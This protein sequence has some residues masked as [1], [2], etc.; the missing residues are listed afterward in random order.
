MLPKKTIAVDPNGNTGKKA[1][2][3]LKKCDEK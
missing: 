1:K 2:E 3:Y